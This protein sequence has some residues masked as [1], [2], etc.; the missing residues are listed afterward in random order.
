MAELKATRDGYGEGLVEAGKNESVVALDADLAESTRSI[1]F[2][3]KYP[4][5]FFDVGIAE[6]NLV[7]TAAGLAASGKIPF[8]SSF[9]VFIT[10]R[11]YDQ[12]R[13]NA[14]ISHLNMKIV[15]SHAGL[16][17]G[18]DGASHQSLE[19]ISLMRGIPGMVVIQPCDFVEAKK[20]TI[21]IAKYKGPVYLRLS[22]GKVP[23]INDEN[24]KFEIGKGIMLKQGKDI[25][26]IATG[27]LVNEALIASDMLKEK[28]IGA[29][30]INIH[31]IK[32][33]DKEIIIKA[34][35]E[36]GCVITAE[37]HSIYGGL[38][39]AV[40]EILAENCPT[41][42]HRIGVNDKFG[43]SGEPSELYKKYGLTAEDIVKAAE[44]LL[45]K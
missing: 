45:K 22:R 14:G 3:E 38:G 2:K 33:I 43:E 24:Y 20:A 21:E 28:G 4:L 37:D 32:P 6:Q 12:I 25:A 15:G 36:T 18:E 5:R 30:V 8:A 42:M 29:R 23:V 26:I 41:K 40:A 11:A 13:L 35:K 7:A 19:D 10:G 9:A 17:T 31:T 44:K 16:L 27:A 1:K 34:A 39:S